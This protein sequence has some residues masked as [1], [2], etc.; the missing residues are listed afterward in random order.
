MGNLVVTFSLARSLSV[1]LAFMGRGRIVLISR[2]EK[3][4]SVASAPAVPRITLSADKYNTNHYSPQCHLR[5]QQQKADPPQ[6]RV[7]ALEQCTFTR[8]FIQIGKGVRQG[9]ILSPCLFNLYA[10]YIMRNAG[11]E[12]TQAGIK[13]ADKN[14]SLVGHG[15]S[16][17]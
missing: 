16:K 7:S 3:S 8:A 15:N 12:E 4:A 14:I 6:S 13:I 11:L 9:C 5:R 1:L 2:V 17:K 10:E